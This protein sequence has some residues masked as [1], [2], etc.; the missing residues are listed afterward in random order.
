MKPNSLIVTSG[1]SE[2]PDWYI[3]VSLY[4]NGLSLDERNEIVTWVN[5]KFPT[6]G[7]VSGIQEGDPVA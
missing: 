2:D 7:N 3:H 6:P 1:K 5:T 4:V